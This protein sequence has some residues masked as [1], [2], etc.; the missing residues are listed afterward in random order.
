MSFPENFFWGAATAAYQIE[1]A[2]CEDGKGPSIW[3]TF[4]SQDGKIWQ[5]Q[6]GQI[7][8]DHYHR[9]EQDVSLMAD[10]GLNAYRLSISWPRVIPEGVGAVNEKGLAF[11]DRLIDA[12]LKE[13]IEPFVTLFHWDFPQALL[14]RDG[15]LNRDC[16]RW[17]ADYVAVVVRALSD[18]VQYWIT[19]N[20]PQ[21]FVHLGYGNGAHAPGLTLPLKHQLLAAHNVLRGHGL[22]VRVVRDEAVKAPKIGWSPGGLVTC[23]RSDDVEMVEAARRY[24]FSITKKDLWNNTWFMDP[25]YCGCYPDD[26]ARVYGSDMPNVQPTDLETIHQPLDFFGINLYHSTEILGHEDGSVERA[27]WPIGHP[28]TTFTWPVDPDVMY[29]GVRFMHDRY[30]LPIYIT[31]NGM[32]NTDWISLDGHVHDPQRIDFISRYVSA[33]QRAIHTGADVRGYFHWTLMDNFEWAEGFKQRFGLI[34]VDYPTQNRILKDSAYWYRQIIQTN[35]DCIADV[36]PMRSIRIHSRPG[37]LAD[38]YCQDRH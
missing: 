28:L 9:Y 30:K 24:T 20:E 35:G 6:S 1:G 4:C 12:L 18:R 14:G 27:S 38:T 33:V 19:L 21:A 7:A 26:G 16:A 8:C 34:Y 11:Y 3:D 36:V 13:E 32:A 25:A 2:A 10:I 23:P 22:A 29:W 31:E 37:V 17:F 15:W 5:N